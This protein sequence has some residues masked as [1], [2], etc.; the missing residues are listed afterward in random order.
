MSRPPVHAGGYGMNGP[1]LNV[2]DTTRA[3]RRNTGGVRNSAP[4]V[5]SGCSQRPY[6]RL[7]IVARHMLARME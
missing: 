3:T 4:V 6:R 2:R 5:V 7:P 1:K